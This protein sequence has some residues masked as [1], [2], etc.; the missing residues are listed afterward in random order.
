MLEAGADFRATDSWGYSVTYYL[1]SAN[2]DPKSDVFKSR[3][4]CMKWLE[5][6]G[7]DFEK[8]KL[9]NAEIDRQNEERRKRTPPPNGVGP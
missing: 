6:K 7:V 2:V 4:K 5:A 9:R 1:L 8:E 3:Q